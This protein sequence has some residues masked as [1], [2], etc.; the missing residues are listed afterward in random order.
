VPTA[1]EPEVIPKAD[2][3]EVSRREVPIM[4]SQISTLSVVH[5]STERGVNPS[6]IRVAFFV[7]VME[8]V[9]AAAAAPRT[10]RG[11]NQVSTSSLVG[12]D[13]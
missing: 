9:L 10:A 7:A 2:A 3:L 6:P 11:A 4:L 5:N 12:T 8:L 13:V 1:R